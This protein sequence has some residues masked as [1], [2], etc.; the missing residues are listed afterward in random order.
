MN[1]KTTR[2]ETWETILAAG[3]KAAAAYRDLVAAADEL[4]E[5]LEYNADYVLRHVLPKKAED[6]RESE[7]VVAWL[8]DNRGEMEKHVFARQSA[9]EDAARR[10][11]LLAKLNLTGDERRL[12]GIE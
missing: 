1:M 5:V 8:K 9:R 4:A 2:N 11:A 6:R 10:D 3:E 7:R 12:L